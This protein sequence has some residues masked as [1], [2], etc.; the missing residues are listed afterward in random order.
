M[1]QSVLPSQSSGNQFLFRCFAA[2]LFLCRSLERGLSADFGY[3]A[4][5]GVASFI[6]GRGFIATNGPNF[7]ACTSGK[8]LC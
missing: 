3:E 4:V 7:G 2:F 8:I 6:F 1:V 5:L